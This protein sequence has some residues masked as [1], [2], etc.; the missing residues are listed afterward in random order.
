MS[1]NNPY[2][3]LIDRDYLYRLLLVECPHQFANIADKIDWQL[4]G[5]LLIVA[6]A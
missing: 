3:R 5:L 6:V 1:I 4:I 2:K